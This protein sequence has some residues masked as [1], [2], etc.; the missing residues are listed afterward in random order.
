MNTRTRVPPQVQ[1]VLRQQA[2]DAERAREINRPALG[3]PRP[4]KGKGTEVAPAKPTAVAMPDTR[5]YRTQYLDSVAPNAIAGRLIKFDK[6]GK[7]VTAD[8]EEAISP[9]RDFVCLADETLIGWIRFS[10]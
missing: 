1:E 7:F 3:K 5:D 8:D 4:Q 2:A 6:S 10:Q 9:D